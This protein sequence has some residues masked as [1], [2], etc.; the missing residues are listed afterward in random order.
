MILQV[1]AVLKRSMQFC[2]QVGT[3]FR[4]L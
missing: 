3:H 2:L 4:R 1:K